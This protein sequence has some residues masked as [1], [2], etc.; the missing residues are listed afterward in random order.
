MAKIEI[1]QEAQKRVQTLT[2]A[3]WDLSYYQTK[4]HHRFFV[5]SPTNW[6]FEASRERNHDNVKLDELAH[7]SAL[8][9]VIGAAWQSFI[10][11]R[12]MIEI[13]QLLD[14]IASFDTEKIDSWGTDAIEEWQAGIIRINELEAF[15][16]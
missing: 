13:Q 6:S 7:R 1:P 16:R 14:R 12:R 8:A 5:K 11:S 10:I 2:A 4:G 15:Y 3:G 9:D